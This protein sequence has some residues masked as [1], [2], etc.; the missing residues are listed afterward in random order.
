ME[1]R[2]L[3]DLKVKER[4]NLEMTSIINFLATIRAVQDGVDKDQKVI[5]YIHEA[6]A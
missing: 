2:S 4:P 1:T 6:F 3:S 5:Y